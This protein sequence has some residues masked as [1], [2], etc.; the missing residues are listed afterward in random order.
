M[1]K[2]ILF[3]AILLAVLLPTVLVFAS[4]ISGQG[5]GTPI[6]SGGG[7]ASG[8]GGGSGVS[9]DESI[10]N[11]K[12]ALVKVGASIVVIGWIVAGILWLMSAG[13]PDKTG[14]AKKAV[15]ACVIGTVL[16]IIAASS[17]Q[18]INDLFKLNGTC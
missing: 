12:D 10:K 11:V 14:I 3:V 1:N 17:C 6:S 15:V 5:A 16:V 13:S 4:D 18:F 7:G 9:A 8:G 2:K